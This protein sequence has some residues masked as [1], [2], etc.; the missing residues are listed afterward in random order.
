[1][2]QPLHKLRAGTCVILTGTPGAGK[3][4]LAASARPSGTVWLLD[5]EGAAHHLHGKAGIHADVRVVQTLSLK[6]L[7]A[8]L[9]ETQRGGKPGDT[10][11]LDSISK[12]LHAMRAHAQQRAGADTDRKASLAYDDHASVNRNLQLIYTRL[13]ELKQGGFHVIVIGHLAMQYERDGNAL[14][15]AGLNLV[16]DRSIGYEADAMLLIEYDG[17]R[18][19]TLT[20]I[21]KQ[22]RFSHLQLNQR[23]PATLAALYGDRLPLTTDARVSASSPAR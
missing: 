18:Q 3:S 19:R 16:A 7:L 22:P 6:Q 21:Q 5:T 10:V 23:Y 11:I 8:A 20:P 1:M 4:H 12:V 13:T 9:H 14:R 2:F 15:A 17:H